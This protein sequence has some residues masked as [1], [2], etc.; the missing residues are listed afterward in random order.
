MNQQIRR[1]YSHT[2]TRVMQEMLVSHGM[3]RE[4]SSETISQF[5]AEAKISA[6]IDLKHSQTKA[7]RTLVVATMSYAI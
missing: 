1:L 2:W 5:K 3:N 6:L 4:Q 7:V